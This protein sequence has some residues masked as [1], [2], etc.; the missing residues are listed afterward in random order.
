MNAKFEVRNGE[1]Y[2]NGQK[3]LKAWESFEGWYWFAT[4]KQDTQDSVINGK[5]YKKDQIWFGY[6]QG[7]YDE[8][9]SFSQS[10]IEAESPRTWEI[11]RQDLPYAGR[12]EINE[13]VKV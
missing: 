3:V 9:G 10:E 8:W 6:V 11:K 13:E 7:F 1:L 2:I 12:R 4:D 5:L